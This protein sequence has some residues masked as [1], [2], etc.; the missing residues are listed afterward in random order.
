MKSYLF[1]FAFASLFFS[2][3]A[4][5]ES[6]FIPNAAVINHQSSISLA[7]YQQRPNHL[8]HL[9]RRKIQHT[10]RAMAAALAFPLPFGVLALHRIYLGTNPHVPVAYIGTVGGV[11]GILPFID[12]CVLI[13]DSD[14]NRFTNNGKVFMWINE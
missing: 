4:D 2:M 13:L 5:A 1:F 14:V 6:S 10:R 9:I 8:I 11:F 3:R 12:F 7:D